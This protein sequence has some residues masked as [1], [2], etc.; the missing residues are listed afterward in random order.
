MSVHKLHKQIAAGAVWM[1]LLRFSVKG[2]GIISTIIL[3]HLLAPEDFGLIALASSIYA[4]VELIRAFGFDI[5]LI[6]NQQATKEHYNTAWTM[7]ILFAIVAST[8]ILLSSHYIS[9]YYHEPRLV[10]ILYIIA[11]IILI[12]GFNNIGT[13]EFRKQLNFTQEFKYQVLTKLSGFCVTIP[14]AWLWHN[15]WALLIG[16]C[17]N[18]LTSLMLSY[19]LQSYRPQISLQASKDLFKFCSWLVFNNAFRFVNNHSQRFIL[20]KI[21]TPHELGIYTV[22]NEIGMLTSTEIIAPINRAAYPGYA[23]LAEQK[24][25]LKITYLKTLSHITLLAIPCALGIVA[26]APVIVPVM[27]GEKWLDAIPLI[28]LMAIASALD[29]LQTNSQYIYLALAKQKITSKLLIL[30]SV[31][32]LPFLFYLTIQHGAIGTANAILITSIIMTPINFFKIGQLLSIKIIDFIKIIYRPLLSSIGMLIIIRGFITSS[33][34]HENT[35]LSLIVILL[36]GVIT[37]HLLLIITWYLSG[38]PKSVERD[39]FRAIQ[40]QLTKWIC[41]A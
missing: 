29:A 39:L 14:L 28:Q 5:A 22:S 7:N 24:Q 30:N 13:V 2:I 41:H 1:I 11:F 25:Q 6:Q 38:Q 35:I 32:F 37:F 40:N 10:N 8:I 33:E 34:L 15:Y 4:M 31:I 36:I 21:T 18:A 23:K 3:A 26:I 20:A 16:M 17:A 27:L 19:L 9:T 12:D